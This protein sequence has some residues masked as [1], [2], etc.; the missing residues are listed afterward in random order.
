MTPEWNGSFAGMTIAKPVSGCW[1]LSPTLASS[2]VTASLSLYIEEA[3]GLRRIAA[4]FRFHRQRAFYVEG[5]Q[6]E[7]D[8]GESLRLF[9]SFRY[10]P[11]QVQRLL[12]A[13]QIVVLEQW[14]TPSEEEGVFL[15]RK[16]G[17]DA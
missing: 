12:R 16:I 2:G 6:I 15:C 17:V 14:V 8:G 11:A 5:E 3:S 7:F 9:F 13:R 4:D 1:P 10:T